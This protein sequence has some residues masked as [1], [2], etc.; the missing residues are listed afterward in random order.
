MERVEGV[1]GGI[2][3]GIDGV[4]ET[5]WNSPGLRTSQIS[6]ALDIPVRTLQRWLGDLRKK[7]RIEFRGRSKTGGYY[8]KGQGSGG[9]NGTVNGEEKTL[10]EFIQNNPGLRRP[11]ISKALGIPVRT[12]QRRLRE[13]SNRNRI[14]FRGSLKT[15]G[16]HVID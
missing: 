5:I 12:L 2:S 9:I 3:G 7:N 13:L 4:L 10:L 15:G 11:Q 1:S 16:Y 6:E 8:I 14:E